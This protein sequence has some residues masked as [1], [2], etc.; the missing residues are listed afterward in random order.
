MRTMTFS[1]DDCHA[2]LCALAIAASVY[3]QDAATMKAAKMEPLCEQFQ[4]QAKVARDLYAR[5]NR[6][7]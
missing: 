2:M 5:F 4:R 6:E 1:N 3:D 7:F